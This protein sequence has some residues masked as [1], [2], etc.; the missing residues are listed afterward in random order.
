[1]IVIIAAAVAWQLD[2]P[3]ARV[4]AVAVTLLGVALGVRAWQYS[5]LLEPDRITV[6]GLL[7]TRVVRRDRIQ[8]VDDFGWLIW[9]GDDGR[10]RRTPLTLFWDPSIWAPDRYHQHAAS[11]LRRVQTWSRQ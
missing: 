1:V 4:L 9:S 3:G 11:G 10:L 8:R 7:R 2:T 5:V 6:R